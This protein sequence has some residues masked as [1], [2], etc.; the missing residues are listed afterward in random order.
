[1]K[2]FIT[3]NK[4]LSLLL[5]LVLVLSV[6]AIV[7]HATVSAAGD[8]SIP[9]GCT[10]GLSGPKAPGTKCPKVSKTKSDLKCGSDQTL[11]KADTGY[12][13]CKDNAKKDPSA[14]PAPSGGG[15]IGQGTGCDSST[16][17]CGHQCGAPDQ[18]P[19]TPSIDIGC[20][21]KGNPIMDALFGIIRFLSDGVGL[22]VIGSIIVGGI[23]FSGSR[24]DPQSTAMAINRIRSSLFALLIYIFAYAMLN[25]LIPGAVLQ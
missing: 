8:N 7:P 9:A 14:T 20:K 6:G 22:V 3:R 11:A 24:G 17:T 19:Y 2:A 5:A 1:M 13:Y 16:G 15:G 21:G 25:Y 23:Q 12:W 10:G 4:K 18:N